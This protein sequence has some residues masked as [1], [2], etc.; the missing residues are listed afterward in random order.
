MNPRR[1]A[2]AGDGPAAPVAAAARTSTTRTG[3]AE[4]EAM[5]VRAAMLYRLLGLAQIGLALAFDATK[6]QYPVAT[7]GLAAAVSAE[8]AVLAAAIF[9]RRRIVPWMIG[10]DTAFIMAA[11]IAE[12]PLTAPGLGQTWVYFM[13]P[14]SMIASMAIGL[15]YRRLDQVLGLTT[16]LAGTY[17][18]GMVVL[19]HDPSWNAVPNAGSYFANTLVA[20][21]VAG[22]VRRAGTRLDVLSDQAAERAALLAAQRERLR[23]ARILHDRVLQT[24]ETLTRGEWI[25][26][27]GFK[28]HIAAEAAWLR[29]LVE[30]GTGSGAADNLSAGLQHLI[31][32]KARLGLEVEFNGTQLRHLAE[33]GQRPGDAEVTQAL[34]DAAGEALTNVAKH[35][36]TSSAL[37]H[38]SVTGERLTVSVLDHGRGFDVTA[39]RRGLGLRESIAG[40]LREVGGS[41]HIESAPG[42]G[43]FVELSVPREPA[44]TDSA[45]AAAA[46]GRAVEAEAAVPGTPRD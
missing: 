43:T 40:R 36:G 9:R 35:S 32:D 8:S 16:C 44:G 45:R 22:Y 18:V 29:G 3:A 34:V 14:F 38:V 37:M 42:T 33:A 19:L 24:L 15:A 46:E 17:I 12:A 30:A 11:L 21:L 6:Y 7:L 10:A 5:L 4:T 28:A 25:S 27:P 20:W 41:V 23:H 1:T 13:Y 2:D 31:S 26:D 39:A